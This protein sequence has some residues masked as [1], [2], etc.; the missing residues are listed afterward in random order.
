VPSE[1]AEEIKRAE[2]ENEE[3]KKRLCLNCVPGLRGKVARQ[4]FIIKVYS[5]LLL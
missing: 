4:Q 1:V 2:E 5:V 3:R